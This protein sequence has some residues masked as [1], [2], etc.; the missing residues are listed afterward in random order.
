MAV[1]D[2][3]ELDRERRP[4][5]R[6]R[7]VRSELRG[8]ERGGERDE[9]VRRRLS[10]PDGLADLAF[11][12]AAHDVHRRLEL[13]QALERRGGERS[14]HGIAADHHRIRPNGLRVGEHRLEGVDVAV[15]VVQREDLHERDGTAADVQPEGCA[16]VGAIDE[17]VRARTSRE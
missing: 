9:V 17:H 4:R 3:V 15:D 6:P 13:L 12:V 14:G 16:T 8:G 11:T 1:E 7:A 10:C 5:K 2:A